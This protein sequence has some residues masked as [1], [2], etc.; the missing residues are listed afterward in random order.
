MASVLLIVRRIVDEHW[1][2]PGENFQCTW[3]HDGP[4]EP[5]V[6]W[7]AKHTEDCFTLDDFVSQQV[8]VEE[9]ASLFANSCS[10]ATQIARAGLSRIHLSERVCCLLRMHF[11]L[12][13]SH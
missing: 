12:L 11:S 7:L 6:A 10:I 2:P 5:Q 1:R 13:P 8:Q 3:S 4:L 9:V